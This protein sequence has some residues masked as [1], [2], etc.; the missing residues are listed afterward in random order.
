[1]L[2]LSSNYLLL[3]KKIALPSFLILL[4]LACH[5]DEKNQ[6]PQSK[7]LAT[8][9]DSL[10]SL[11]QT[12]PDSLL[13]KENLLQF[14]RDSGRYDKAIQTN[15]NFLKKDSMNPRLHHTLGLLYLE[16]DDTLNALASFSQAYNIYNNAS[17][18]IYAGAIYANKKDVKALIISDTLLKNFYEKSAKEAWLIKGIYFSGISQTQKAI[19]CFDSAIQIRFSFTEAYLEKAKT[20][21]NIHHYKEAIQ[22]LE[23][24]VT[25]NNN[26]PDA[27]IIMGE[28]YERLNETNNAQ[29]AYE[30]ALMY[31]A[32]N[33]DAKAA[34]KRLRP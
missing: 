15:L 19:A 21:K 26:C 13:P 11:I 17:D 12:H 27:F 24:A 10:L 5:V 7:K 18:L 25:I 4:L 16:N 9:E 14:Y 20:L 23:K 31:E 3:N 28:C 33:Q 30:Q 34:L 8:T 22:T 32:E 1:M 29:N 6:Y 2:I